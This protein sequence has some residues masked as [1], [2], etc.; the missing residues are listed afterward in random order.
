MFIQDG[1]EFV[2]N[3]PC[4]RSIAARV[5]RINFGVQALL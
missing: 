2:G 3:V 4:M 1:L 5:H